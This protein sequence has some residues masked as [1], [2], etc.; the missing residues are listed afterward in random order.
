MGKID[1][2]TKDYMSDNERF[3]DLFNFFVYD[4]RQVIEPDGLRE[5]DTA[6]VALPHGKEGASENVQ[7]FR[8]SI[9]SWTV[10]RDERAEYLLLAV[11]DQTETHYAMPVRNMVSDALQYAKQVKETA[12]LHRRAKDW[13]GNSPKVNSG[14]FLGGFYKEDGLIPVITLVVYWSSKEWDGPRSIHEMFGSEYEELLA[15]IPDYKMNLVTPQQIADEDFSKFRTSLA[16]AF[17][18]I[19]YSADRKRLDAL[20]EEDEKFHS[21]DRATAE[22]LNEITDSRLKF[23][24]KEGAVNMCLA[25][26]EMR[27]EAEEKGRREAEKKMGSAIDEMR[28]EAEEK[29][30]REAEKKMGSAIDEMRRE[31]EEKERKDA[32]HVI[33]Q[34]LNDGK[35]SLDEVPQYFPNVSM[36]NV[37][38]AVRA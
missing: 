6:L 13:R 14:E 31:A 26:D 15:L 28:R 36:E 23:E 27:R 10:M 8:D 9:K 34:M 37:K 33:I 17:R 1:V 25:I 12:A 32:E 22:L 24:E 18:Y 30:R 20:M 11:E 16:E 19:K 4:G 5:L 7:R 2:K 35:L 3:A 21:L 38:Q 29:G